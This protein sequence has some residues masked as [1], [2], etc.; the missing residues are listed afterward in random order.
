MNKFKTKTVDL[1][2]TA[3]P[4][5]L[6]RKLVHLS[7]H[8]ARS[9]FEKFSHVHCVSPHMESAL[10]SL[11]SRGFSPHTVIDVGA[12]D[13]LWSNL[14]RET[15]PA[16]RIVMIEPNKRKELDLV[17]ETIGGIVY[18]E[19]LGATDGVKV[20]FNVME[21]G[22]SVM[23]ENSPI[24]RV[25]ETRTLTTL[26]SLELALSGNSNF[27]KVDV[28]GYELEVLK[29]A[30]RSLTAF[31]AILLEVSLIE[32]N[33]GAPLLHEVVAFMAQLDFVAAEISEI[34]RRPLDHA[35]SQIDIVFVRRD[36]RLLADRRYC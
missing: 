21:S 4:Q 1:L 35:T 25:V 32:I 15:W 24:A 10:A 7:F 33:K 18:S 12:L 14:A 28:Q 19:L 8:L 31:E 6:R 3:L 27:L 22:S 20:P 26:D 9:D 13:G 36:S 30:S 34:H 5:N 11:K 23:S 2:K 17:A 16:S 29:G